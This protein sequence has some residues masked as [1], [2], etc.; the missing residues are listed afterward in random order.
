MKCILLSAGKGERLLPYTKQKPK[1][2]I[3]V[4]GTN[5]LEIWL[6]KLSQIN[7][8]E[9][10]IN[11]HHLNEVLEKEVL[12]ICKKLNIKNYRIY[13]EKVLLGTA[14]TIW[15]LKDEI[16]DDFFVINTDVYAEINLELMRNQFYNEKINCLIA[17]DY[18]LDTNGCGL[19]NFSTNNKVS[20]LIEKN[21]DNKPGFVYSG[22][23]IFNRNIF[24]Y[25]PFKDF[26]QKSYEGLDTG[27]HVL[28]RILDTTKG[29]RINKKVI[30]LR[31]EKKLFEL[32]KYINKHKD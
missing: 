32:N 27:F 30:D 5:L 21:H 3:D 24:K 25:L 6:K 12:S 13:F 16:K 26:S 19:I 8:S 15:S 2:L 14:G 22:I 11:T 4:G 10:I 31:D 17:Y 20:E 1:C 23:L 9:I 28:P 29:F 7:I 18:R